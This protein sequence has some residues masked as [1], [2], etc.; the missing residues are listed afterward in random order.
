MDGLSNRASRR[1]SVGF[2]A[3]AVA[4]VG[5]I[6]VLAKAQVLG[7]AL[8]NAEAIPL[9]PA[10]EQADLKQVRELQQTPR[11]F[12][13]W[14]AD[15]VRGPIEIAPSQL[16]VPLA[17]VLLGTLRCSPHVRV[18]H[19]TPAIQAAN[20]YEAQCSSTGAR[21]WSRSSSTRA[22]PSAAR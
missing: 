11:G 13:N 19:D 3:L 9:P 7:P 14:W 20:V 5:A 16:E 18:L 6:G 22:T 15:V 8:E 12:R 10:V 4:L 2:V 17:E 1:R 21:S